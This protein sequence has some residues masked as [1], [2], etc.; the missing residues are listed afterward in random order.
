MS[1]NGENSEPIVDYRTVVT[2]ETDRVV[3]RYSPAMR[4]GS[5]LL[6]L[7][8]V[9]VATGIVA[10][11][12]RLGLHVAAVVLGVFASALLLLWAWSI[13]RIARL[14]HDHP[15]VVI[16]DTG[17]RPEHHGAETAITADDVVSLELC[18]PRKLDKTTRLYARVRG[19]EYHLFLY[20]HEL[21]TRVRELAN[22]LS[23][24]WN[25]GVVRS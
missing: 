18:G 17:V 15:L 1:L 25:R 19:E 16:T 4:R 5:V 21:G 24:R 8:G 23:N 14:H 20:Q 11:L 2:Q 10:E 7:G 22:D 13:A 9:I 12:V 3:V 6:L